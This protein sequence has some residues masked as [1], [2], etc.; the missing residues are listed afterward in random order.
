MVT[1]C[2][3]PSEI[4]RHYGNPEVILGYYIQDSKIVAYNGLLEEIECSE[5]PF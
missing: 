2:L 3:P 5:A 1:K 4:K